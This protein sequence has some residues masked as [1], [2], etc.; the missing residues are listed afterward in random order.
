[1]YLETV[2]FQS[3]VP[4]DVTLLDFFFAFFFVVRSC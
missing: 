1:M 3:D 2:N 4:V